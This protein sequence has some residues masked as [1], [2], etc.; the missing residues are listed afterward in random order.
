MKK[1]DTL[2][3]AGL[4]LL[5]CNWRAYVSE[6]EIAVYRITDGVEALYDAV[7]ATFNAICPELNIEVIK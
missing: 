7:N 6:R 4:A 1:H 3:E 5:H 2:R